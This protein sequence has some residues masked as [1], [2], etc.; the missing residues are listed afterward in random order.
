MNILRISVW[1]YLGI[2][3]AYLLGPL[4]IMSAI[5]FGAV[6]ASCRSEAEQTLAELGGA[7]FEVRLH[8]AALVLPR[9]DERL[10]AALLD[11]RR[12]FVRDPGLVEQ[13]LGILA[14]ATATPT[15]RVIRRRRISRDC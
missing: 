8:R 1:I 5:P 3:F 12:I 10:Q 7:L 11:E 6:G 13:L 15:T 14:T 9:E 2:F 4:I